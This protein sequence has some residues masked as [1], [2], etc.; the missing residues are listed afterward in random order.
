MYNLD[1]GSLVLA[2]AFLTLSTKRP[3]LD[4]YMNYFLKECNRYERIVEKFKTLTRTL[5]NDTIVEGTRTR[6]YCK[7]IGLSLSYET[8][9]CST[10]I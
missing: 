8:R 3:N 4:L 10:P 1:E 9:V 6:R 5:F 7:D 2:S